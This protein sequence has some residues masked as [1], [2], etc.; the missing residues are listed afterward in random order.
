M[1]LASVKQHRDDNSSPTHWVLLVLRRNLHR[2][3]REDVQLTER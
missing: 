2:V 3:Y 1:G